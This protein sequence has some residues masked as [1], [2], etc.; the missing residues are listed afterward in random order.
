MIVAY[1]LWY[2][3]DTNHDLTHFYLLTYRHYKL[4]NA[5]QKSLLDAKRIKRLE[6]LDFI[7]VARGAE[8][9]SEIEKKKK[10]EKG[11]AKWNRHFKELKEYKAKNGDCLVPKCFEE[12]RALASWVYNQ[13]FQ[14]KKMNE[15]VDVPLDEERIKK[16]NAVGFCWKAKTNEAW[17]ESDRVRRRE[18]S[19]D[20]WDEKF[21]ALVDFKKK[22]GHTCVPKTYKPD[23]PLSSWVFRMRRQ[24]GFRMAGKINNM[25]D[26]R[27]ERLKKVSY[28]WC[29]K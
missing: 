1:L 25:S 4:F 13:R 24:Y 7:F 15:G 20:G 19:Q 28:N 6:K 2:F 18:K 3:T 26:D 16:L 21:E 12:N 17:R 9:Q 11:I 29:R 27:L 22:H 5:K 8:I 14:F 10:R 23:Q